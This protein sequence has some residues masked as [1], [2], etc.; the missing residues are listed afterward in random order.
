[1]IASVLADNLLTAP[2]VA[3]VIALIATLFKFD[4][5][6]PEAMYPIL[7]TFLLLAIGLKGGRS[8]AESSLSDLWKPLLGSL[9]LGVIT[10]LVAFFLFRALGK[11][12]ITNAAA[13]A[14]H[15]GSVSAVTFTVVI[16]SLDTQ[17]ISYE[18][19]V[20]GLLA[21]LEIVGIIVALFLARKEKSSAHWKE[22]LAEVIRGRSIA[23][24]VAGMLIGLI[25]GDERLQPTDGVFVQLFA[26]AL[27]LFLIEMGV[28]AAE[29]LRDIR[30]A[31]LQVLVLGIAIPIINGS[32]GAVVGSVVGLS[33]GGIAVLATLAASA[34]YI[35]APAAVRIALPQASPGLYVTASLGVT[36]PFNLVLGI[37]LYIAIAQRLS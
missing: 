32:I 5:R 6:L 31:G 30:H 2:V 36:F 15:Y 3:F 12:D 29:R 10:P 34:S 14:A 18:G 20:A 37:P 17:E 22:G 24:L 11:I 8:L 26:G 28:L 9:L 7:S 35:A 21:I 1:M 27:A 16:T 4:L 13:L 25:V 19:F 33:T 23:F